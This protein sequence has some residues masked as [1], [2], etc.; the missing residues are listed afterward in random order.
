RYGTHRT[1][2]VGGSDR[3][4]DGLAVNAHR[5]RCWIGGDFDACCSDGIDHRIRVIGIGTRAEHRDSGRS[6]HGTGV[7]VAGGQ[8]LREASRNRRLART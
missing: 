6:I 5:W 2:H 3:V 1:R 8:P 7:E 4:I